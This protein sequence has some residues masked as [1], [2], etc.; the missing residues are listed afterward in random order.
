MD[1]LGSLSG[2]RTIILG[3][4]QRLRADDGLGPEICARIAGQVHT[5]VIDAGPVP[6]NFIGPILRSRPQ[7]VILIDAVDLGLAPGSVMVLGPEDLSGC[8]IAVQ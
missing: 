1:L 4:G 3:V 2:Q 7:N 5:E 8:G 6:E